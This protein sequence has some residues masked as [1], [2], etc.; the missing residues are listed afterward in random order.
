[1][2]KIISRTILFVLVTYVIIG[3]IGYATFSSN[4]NIL[5]DVNISNGIILVAYGY[6]LDGTTRAYPMLVLIVIKIS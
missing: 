3:I 4:L 1:M 2:K 5:S 6:N